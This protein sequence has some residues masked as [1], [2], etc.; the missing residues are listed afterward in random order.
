MV[1]SDVESPPEVGSDATGG[2]SM[3]E[4]TIAWSASGGSNIESTPE[5]GPTATGFQLR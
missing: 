5:V 4:P 1:G 2:D 3:S